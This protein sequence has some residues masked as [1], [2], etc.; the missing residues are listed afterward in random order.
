MKLI[1]EL[2]ESV[3]VLE[4]TT[5]SGKKKL[6]IE[7]IFLQS[8]IAN[9]NNRIYPQHIMEK[10]VARYLKESVDKNKAWGELGHPSGPQIN[11]ERASHIIKSLVREGKNYVGKA[12]IL[13][14]PMGN[15]VRGLIESGGSIGVSSRGLGSLRPISGGINEVMDDFKLATA[16]DIVADPSAPDAFVNGIMEGVEWFHDGTTYREQRIDE[17][18]RTIRGAS[19]R[20]L[21][22]AKLQAFNNFMRLIAEN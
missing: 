7:G 4:E 18:K 20:Q 6:F 21:E 12:E 10:E 15:I 2:N 19:R 22:E 9:K 5:A 3:K 11:L 13:D 1:T 14:T 16:A 8:G 17:V